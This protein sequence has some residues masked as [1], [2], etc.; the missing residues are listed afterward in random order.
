MGNQLEL[1]VG[2]RGG[3]LPRVVGLEC[4]SPAR[5]GT[6]GAQVLCAHERLPRELSPSWWAGT[7]CWSRLHI[8]L[9]ARGS[10]TFPWAGP[11]QSQVLGASAQCSPLLALRN[12]A[13]ASCVPG[14]SS[15]WLCS[16]VSRCGPGKPQVTSFPLLPSPTATRGGGVG[17]E[18]WGCRWVRRAQG[19]C[20]QRF[21]D[22]EPI[23]PAVH[24][25]SAL[26]FS[27]PL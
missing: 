7:S 20:R 24:P 23:R 22:I 14:A 4:C 19:R 26:I 12:G 5:A 6:E 27:S 25:L 9:Q 15:L 1:P 11:Q 13:G 8:P 10:G 17:T 16:S 3:S 2:T 18:R 21:K